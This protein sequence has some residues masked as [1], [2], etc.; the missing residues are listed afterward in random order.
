M[1]KKAAVAEKRQRSMTDEHKAALAEGREQGRVVRRYLE[2]LEAH[3]PK[4]GRKRTPE[5]IKKQ[6]AALDQKLAAADPLNRL[7]LTQERMDLEAEVTAK[8]EAL[9]PTE[10]EDEFVQAA[11]D[12]GRR[13]GIS[14]AAWRGAGVPPTVLKQAGILRGQGAEH[15]GGGLHPQLHRGAQELEA[16]VLLQRAGQEAGLGEDLEAVADAEHGAPGAGEVGYRAHHRREA[17]DGAG[18]QVVA[19]GETPRQHHAV[20]PP[21]GGLVVPQQLGLAPQARH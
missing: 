7:L 6:L 12:Y 1:A 11:A 15:A 14:Y 18:A 21:Q 16:P 20:H 13:K 10:L 2:A 3:R 5:S 9:D 19:V 8:E 4:R 17:G